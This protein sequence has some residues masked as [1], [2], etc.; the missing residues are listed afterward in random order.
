MLSWIVGFLAVAVLGTLTV[1]GGW[2]LWTYSREEDEFDPGA[3]RTQGNFEIRRPGRSWRYDKDTQVKMKVNLAYRQ[4]RPRNHFSIFF[5][6]YRTRSPSNAELVDQALKKLR[7]FFAQVDY[8]DPFAKKGEPATLGDRPAFV[9]EF[10]ATDAQEVEFSGQ[11]YMMTEQGYGYWF[12][13]WCP[14][15]DREAVLDKWESVRQGFTLLDERTGWTPRPRETEVFTGTVVPFQLNYAKDLWRREVNAPESDGAVDLEL[16]GF[17]PTV[18]EESGRKKVVEHASRAA[19]VQV[20]VLPRVDKLDSAEQAVCEHILKRE[21]PA[22]PQ[23]KFEPINDKKTGQPFRSPRVG[24]FTG[25]LSKFELKLGPENS[26]YVVLGVVHRPG[27]V[28]AV[29][30]DCPWDRRDFWEQEFKALLET[31]RQRR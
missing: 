11:C 1:A 13:T 5:R 27:E 21:T 31:V 26:R 19:T 29:Y 10:V 6:D 25:R 4:R 30:C 22:H 3:L 28:L 14:S 17:E 7:G 23:V 24:A 8:E 9:L 20:M 16:R 12:F 18:D 15:E 2:M